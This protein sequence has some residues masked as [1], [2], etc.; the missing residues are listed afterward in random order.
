MYLSFEKQNFT[1]TIFFN[2]NKIDKMIR[3]LESKSVLL[4]WD[5]LRSNLG[6]IYG[7]GSFAVLYRTRTEFMSFFALFKKKNS[8]LYETVQS[9]KSA[10]M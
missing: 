5:H 1:F 2:Y 6:I 9:G 3:Q 8:P 10:I 7:W 4:F